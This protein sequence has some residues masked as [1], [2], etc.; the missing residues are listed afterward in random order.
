MSLASA[1]A[2]HK[3]KPKVKK[4]PKVPLPT[5]K[6]EPGEKKGRGRPSAYSPEIGDK[7]CER[8]A[9]R[10]PLSK[11][12][13][14][15]DMPCEATIY[16]WRLQY[17]DFAEKVAHA[18]EHRALAR[19]DYMDEVV[20]DVRTGKLDPQAGRVVLE[21]ERWQ[22]G[23][24]MPKVFG[25]KLDVTSAGKAI[26]SASDLDIAKALARALAAQAL[27]APEPLDAESV[28]VKD[29]EKA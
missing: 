25:D 3:A 21:S 22:A 10:E 12:T 11:I 18:R 1:R 17:P 29:E 6:P 20:D 7:L 24:E 8:I 13:R 4:T 26:S 2:A 16:K 19:A 28:P 5:P 9:M 15:D 14:D 27:P 23:K